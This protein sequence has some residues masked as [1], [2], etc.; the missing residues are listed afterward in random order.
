M[1][2]DA[3]TTFSAQLE[4]FVSVTSPVLIVCQS[5][6][7]TSSDQTS[8]LAWLQ[9]TGNN[10]IV[11]G[12]LICIHCAALLTAIHWSDIVAVTSQLFSFSTT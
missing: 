7:F 2:D 5:A 8:P 10:E 3:I 11:T 1:R 9:R 6:P 12:H 4:S